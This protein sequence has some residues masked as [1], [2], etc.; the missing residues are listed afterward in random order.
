MRFIFQYFNISTCAQNTAFSFSCDKI[1]I[2]L[3]S[4]KSWLVH[5][6]KLT[7]QNHGIWWI[8]NFHKQIFTHFRIYLVYFETLRILPFLV[9]FTS[10]FTCFD[11]CMPEKPMQYLLLIENV[12]RSLV[13]SNNLTCGVNIY[14]YAFVLKL[15]YDLS[16][17][18]GN[19]PVTIGYR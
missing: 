14:C 9:Y 6:N 19:T 17:V 10:S 11:I 4:K 7:Q 1:V 16:L 3:R 5:Q 18:T 13:D 15:H 2:F 8:N 12:F